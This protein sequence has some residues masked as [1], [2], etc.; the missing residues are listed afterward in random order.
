MANIAYARISFKKG[1]NGRLNLDTSRLYRADIVDSEIS[2]LKSDMLSRVSKAR[3]ISCLRNMSW[4]VPYGNVFIMSFC[5]SIDV[6]GWVDVKPNTTIGSNG[7]VNSYLN[8]S[9]QVTDYIDVHGFSAFTSFFDDDLGA[10]INYAV[11][12]YG[13][14]KSFVGNAT[15]PASSTGANPGNVKRFFPSDTHYVRLLLTNALIEDLRG[16]YTGRM[17]KIN[18][19]DS[20]DV[21]TKRTY[22]L[23]EVEDFDL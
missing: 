17:L 6:N 5:D 20:N 12:C 22:V 10:S 18:L 19:T 1:F 9:R 2:T 3:L 8:A 7:A 21:L 23:V 11:Y 13:Q 16:V 15:S 14:D 4:S